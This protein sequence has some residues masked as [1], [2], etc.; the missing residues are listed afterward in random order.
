[1]VKIFTGGSREVIKELK[2]NSGDES[3]I[4]V[5]RPTSVEFTIRIVIRH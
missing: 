3:G 5:F 1:M 4:R 2:R